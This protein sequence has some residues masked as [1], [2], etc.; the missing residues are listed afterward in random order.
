M[1]IEIPLELSM[2]NFLKL[3]SQIS[4]SLLELTISEKITAKHPGTDVAVK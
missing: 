1:V 4:I 2:R 3:D